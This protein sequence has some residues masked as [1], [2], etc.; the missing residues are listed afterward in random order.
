MKIH[1]ACWCDGGVTQR[2]RRGS[3]ADIAVQTAKR[4]AG[5][6]LLR[7][8]YVGNT[9]LDTVYSFEYLGARM[10]CDGADNADVRHRMAIAQTAFRS[11]SSIIMGRPPV[12]ARVEAEDVPACWVFDA[13]TRI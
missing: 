3:L 6:A 4:R 12:V 13:D 9:P 11:L 1:A 7:H 10:Q 8:V 2:S 5:K